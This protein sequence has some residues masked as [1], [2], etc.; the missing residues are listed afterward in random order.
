MSVLPEFNQAVDMI[1]RAIQAPSG[2]FALENDAT[3]MDFIGGQI[4]PRLSRA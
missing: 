3:L 2:V 1:V 4:W